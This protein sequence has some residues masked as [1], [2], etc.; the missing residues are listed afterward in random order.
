MRNKWTIYPMYSEITRGRVRNG[1][2]Y[3]PVNSSAFM[4][5]LFHEDF[6]SIIETNEVLYTVF[7]STIEGKSL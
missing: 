1:E 2:I 5:R 7:V 3:A 6:S 4:Y